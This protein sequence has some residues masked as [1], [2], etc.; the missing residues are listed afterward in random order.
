VGTQL[1]A[2][3]IDVANSAVATSATIEQQPLRAGSGPGG[4]S[5]GSSSS[6]KSSA[7]PSS[8]RPS[9]YPAYS[10]RT[11]P[12]YD[13]CVMQAPDGKPLSTCNTK[14]ARWYL[15]RGIAGS[16]L[17]WHVAYEASV[18]RAR[19]DR[20]C[21]VADVPQGT[22]SDSP[23][24]CSIFARSEY[25]LALQAGGGAFACQISP[26]YSGYCEY[27]VA[28]LAGRMGLAKHSLSEA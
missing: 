18:S 12:L 11:R 2:A 24:P 27:S 20:R 3:L 8:S 21:A 15:N 1:P 17:G 25:L 22:L 16:R 13:N 23:G 28:A 9:N 6:S 7:R 5:D 10:L 19:I 14:K 4:S 26:S